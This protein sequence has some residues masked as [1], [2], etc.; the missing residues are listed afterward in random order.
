VATAATALYAGVWVYAILFPK[1]GDNDSDGVLILLSGLVYLIIVAIWVGQAAALR[2]KRSD[3]QSPRRPEY[4][5]GAI[6]R[7]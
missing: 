5:A 3:G 1:G 7:A 4:G 6:S 2:E